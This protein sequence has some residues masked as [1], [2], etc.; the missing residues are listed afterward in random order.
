MGT[1]YYD[2]KWLCYNFQLY[3]FYSNSRM[4]REKSWLLTKAFYNSVAQDSTKK[5]DVFR[6]CRQSHSTITLTL[7]TLH[8]NRKY[9][10]YRDRL[11]PRKSQKPSTRAL[12]QLQWRT[13]Y[14]EQG[15]A[16]IFLFHACALLNNLARLL[17][18]G[19]HSLLIHL[20]LDE[21][22]KLVVNF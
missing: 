21:Q 22:G 16:T 5:Y 9:F 4:E 2:F 7:R 20:K 13:F 3:V 19:F 1:I 12:N 18:F 17:I 8:E 6:E 14:T 15:L 11:E 10:T